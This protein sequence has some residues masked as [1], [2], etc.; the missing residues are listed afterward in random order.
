MS[1]AGLFLA[2]LIPGI[3]IGVGLLVACYVHGRWYHDQPVPPMSTKASACPTPSPTLRPPV[4][5]PAT[6]SG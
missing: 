2:G 4:A 1:V 6:A 3:L 5:S